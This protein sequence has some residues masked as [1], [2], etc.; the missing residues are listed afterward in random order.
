MNKKNALMECFHENMNK[1]S[2]VD[3]KDHMFNERS[4]LIMGILQ[5]NFRKII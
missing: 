4:S 5:N 3:E 2:N 1:G